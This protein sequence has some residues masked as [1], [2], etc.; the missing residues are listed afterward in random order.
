MIEVTYDYIMT[1]YSKYY[2]KTNITQIPMT[3]DKTTIKCKWKRQ[4]SSIRCI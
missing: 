4:K 2:L 3:S 1:Y